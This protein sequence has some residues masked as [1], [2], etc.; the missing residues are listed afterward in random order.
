MGCFL[1]PDMHM[2]FAFLPFAGGWGWTISAIAACRRM[3]ILLEDEPSV[4]RAAIVFHGDTQSKWW[5]E[6]LPL[7]QAERSCAVL[8][9]DISAALPPFC[10]ATS[11]LQHGTEG[12]LALSALCCHRLQRALGTEWGHDNSPDLCS[13]SLIAKLPSIPLWNGHFQWVVF[14][15]SLIFGWSAESHLSWIILLPQA[16]LPGESH[17]W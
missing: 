9:G 16:L 11:A 4:R 10:R 13:F 7:C 1:W 17:M 5:A 2:S 15:A 8:R 3:F 12:R 14:R 6:I